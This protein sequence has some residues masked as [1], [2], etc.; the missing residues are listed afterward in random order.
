MKKLKKEELLAIKAG[1]ISATYINAIA[2]GIDAILDL[3][4]SFGTAIR[5]WVTD[6]VCTP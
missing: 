6:S 2:K 4:R 5:R 1:A 3:G